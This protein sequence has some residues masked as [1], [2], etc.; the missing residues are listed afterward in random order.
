M[1]SL[2]EIASAREL[3]LNLTLRE[4]RSKYKRSVLGWTWSLLNPLATMVIFTIVFSKLL[5]I[6]P[7]PGNPS[8]LD[9]FALFLLCGLLPWN[10]LSNSMSG[11]A[12]A[13]VANANLVKKVYFPRET[14]VAANTASW[15]FS[16]LIEMGVLC[17]A[18]LFV[19]NMVLPWLPMLIVLIAVQ[20]MFVLGIALLLAALNVYFRDTQH[21]LGI[22]LQLWFYATPIVYP[23]T[24]VQEHVSP[25]TLRLYQLNPM[26]EFVG[27]YRNVLYDLRMPSAATMA[28]LLFASV[29][30][31]L[32]GHIVF[33]RL[34]PKLAEEL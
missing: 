3:F 16:L 34:E 1:S 5:K 12:V 27:A 29:V 23:L 21:L 19:G 31:L 25:A 13:L 8:G 11:G 17:V 4:L 10:F 24:Q 18:L 2:R 15:L 6:T 33:N 14:L 9:V 32:V 28:Y 26:V 30:S 20:T 7:D 22:L